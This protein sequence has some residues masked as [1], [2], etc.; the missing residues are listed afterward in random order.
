MT[1]D[2]L[3]TSDHRAACS[4]LERTAASGRAHGYL[5]HGPKPTPKLA[6]AE[7][8][9]ARLLDCLPS[10]LDLQPTFV[11]L[12]RPVDEKTGEKKKMIPVDAIEG[13]VGRLALSNIGNKPKVAILEDAHLLNDH[14]QNA[15]LKTVEEPSGQTVL[16]LL[17]DDPSG[18]LPTLRSRVVP[19]DLRPTSQEIGRAFEVLMPDVRAFVGASQSRRL[20][21]AVAMTKGDEAQAADA[22]QDFVEALAYDVHSTFLVKCATMSSEER[23]AY[24]RALARL[25][26]TPRL[27]R[28]NAS[29]TLVLESLALSL[30]SG[31]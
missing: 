8:F 12:A 6:I 5:L 14:A 28:E 27:L 9:A 11:R 26:D 25:A 22:I 21:T 24:V 31:H 4:A 18:V 13:L 16:L 2:F 30:P 7:A 19:I 15:L 23:R 3:G 1:T 20:L 17:A 29:A 10:S